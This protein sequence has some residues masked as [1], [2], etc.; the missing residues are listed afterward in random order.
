[1][2]L[3]LIF[4][5]RKCSSSGLHNSDMFLHTLMTRVHHIRTHPWSWDHRARHS[6]WPGCWCHTLLHRNALWNWHVHH[7]SIRCHATSIYHTCTIQRNTEWK[8][9]QRQ[10]LV[11]QAQDCKTLI[12]GRPFKGIFV[13]GDH[14]L[15]KQKLI[16]DKNPSQLRELSRKRK[17]VHGS[18]TVPLIEVLLYSDN[19]KKISIGSVDCGYTCKWLIQALVA[20]SLHRRLSQV[21]LSN[22]GLLPVCLKREWEQDST[23]GLFVV[24][25]RRSGCIV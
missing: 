9:L 20:S 15:G 12:R 22:V 8:F 11:M 2:D 21:N 19:T 18:D 24:K 5:H 23:Q 4:R 7:G 17:R 14:F 13:Q 1:M 25:M 16:F 6:C 3:H 10:L